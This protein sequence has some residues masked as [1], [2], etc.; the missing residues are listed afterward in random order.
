MKYRIE[1]ITYKNGRQ[2]FFAQVKTMFFWKYIYCEGGTGIQE[3]VPQRTREKALER[4]DLHL[5]GNKSIKSI[6]FEYINK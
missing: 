4:I 2:D 5:A 1:I 6:E 3:S